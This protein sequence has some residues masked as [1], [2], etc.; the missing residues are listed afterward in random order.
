[1]K[2][3]SPQ[4]QAEL[5]SQTA[6]IDTG[7]LITR[8][9]GKQFGFTSAD[10]AVALTTGKPSVGVFTQTIFAG[11]TVYNFGN[12]ATFIIGSVP[13]QMLTSISGA[14]PHSV[15][16]GSDFAASITNLM[17]AINYDTATKTV[18]YSD[19]G[20][21]NPDVS[22]SALGD[23]L[24][25]TSL[26]NLGEISDAYV[27]QFFPASGYGAGSWGAA[28][29][30][31]GSVLYSPTSG[32]NPSAVVSKGN[33]SVDNMEAQVLTSDLITEEDLA[34]G[35]WDNAAVEVFWFCPYEPQ[36]GIIPLRGGMLGEIVIKDGQWTTQLRSL[37][38]QLQQ[39]FGYFYTLQ[40]GAQLGDARCKV[41]LAVPAWQPNTAYKLGLL[42]DAGVGM[43]VQ[44]TIPND[45]WY[46]AQYTTRGP[47][48]VDGSA[49]FGLGTNATPEAGLTAPGIVYN[50]GTSTI[51]VTGPGVTSQTNTGAAGSGAGTGAT[52]TLTTAGNFVGSEEIIVGGIT[53]T[54]KVTPA[55]ANDIFIG[56]DLNTSLTNVAAAINNNALSTQ[57]F[58]GTSYNPQITA[59]VV[60]GTLVCTADPVLGAAG[61]TIPANYI[62][63]GGTAAS[64][65]GTAFSGGITGSVQG[66]AGT[67]CTGI[68]L[69]SLVSAQA[70]AYDDVNPSAN[71]N[72]DGQIFLIGDTTY[73]FRLSP[74]KPYD[75]Q[76]DNSSGHGVGSMLTA[77][78]ATINHGTS[79]GYAYAGTPTN[80]QC[81]AVYNGGA[82]QA[83][84]TITA[85]NPPY[86]GSEGSVVQTVYTPV[87]G[88][89]VAGGFTFTTLTGG[90]GID[91]SAVQ[92]PSQPGQGLSAN[93]D[94]GPNDNTQ[95]AVGAANQGLNEFTFFPT[96]VDIFGIVI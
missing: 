80:P 27:T 38:Q 84:M 10:F 67:P 49:S 47:S 8:N 33:M 82:Y 50:G 4:L 64:W 74:S 18:T 56:V 13:Y 55:Q 28:T 6:R 71:G 81:T 52:D 15:L 34:G 90:V 11:P 40:C 88:F 69:Q 46:V 25:V 43:I 63:F 45:F 21:A 14:V 12:G 92:A 87:P 22:A 66:A 62:S 37:L 9:D 42:S 5:N 96:N 48:Y 77:L 61:N 94:L 86:V 16:I 95:I 76:L 17:N 57:A 26:Y 2:L 23:V 7:W 41:K 78:A 44:P 68:W 31:G 60:T 59:S 3:I 53:Y 70:D 36:W 24:T 83:S 30:Q 54:M 58:P 20:G 85:S 51:P 35:V 93:D 29:L 39:P 79:G 65:T 19:G 32:F 1:M 72:A 75:I 89:P 73:T 91:A